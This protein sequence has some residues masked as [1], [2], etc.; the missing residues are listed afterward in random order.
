MFYEGRLHR[1]AGR[2]SLTYLKGDVYLSAATLA[3]QESDHGSVGV[4]KR[5]L[6]GK[7]WTP[8]AVLIIQNAVQPCERCQLMHRPI[9]DDS[10][11]EPMNL[12]GPF[13]R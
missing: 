11:L 12:V 13:D 3:Q 10:G 4:I 1:R 5:I 6:E 7:A 9:A 8:D 2:M